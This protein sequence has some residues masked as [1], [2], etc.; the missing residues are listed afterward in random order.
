MIKEA[1]GTG[2]TLDEAK[3]AALKALGAPEDADVKYDVIERPKAKVLG[4]FG[5]SSAELIMRL[6]T[7][8]LQ[9]LR[10]IFRPF[11][12]A[13]ALKTLRFPL[14][15]TK[16][17]SASKSAAETTTARLSAEGARLLTPFSI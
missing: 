13:S 9:R 5:G 2:A 12:K 14:K 1:F 16:R 15:Q 8:P 17:M 4:L 3:E 10:I 7:I 11:S 6:R